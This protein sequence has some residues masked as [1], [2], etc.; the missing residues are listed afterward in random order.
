MFYIFIIFKSIKL[1]WVFIKLSSSCLKLFI[2]D[3]LEDLD[4]EK[5]NIFIILSTFILSIGYNGYYKKH[6]TD[7]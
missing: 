3:I 2:D 4:F 7:L 5:F 6:R 1:F